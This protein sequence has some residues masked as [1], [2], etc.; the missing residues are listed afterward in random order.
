V[1]LGIV[2]HSCYPCVVWLF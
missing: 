2:M 1:S